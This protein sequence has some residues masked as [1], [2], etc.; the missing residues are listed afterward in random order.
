MKSARV[1]AFDSTLQTTNLWITEILQR[2]HWRDRHAAYH[3]LRSVLH[4]LRDR[5]TIEKVVALGA[6]L[7]M[8]IR[9]FY[10]EGWH[11]LASLTKNE[12]RRNSWNAFANPI[13]PFPKSAWKELFM[14]C[15]A[16]LPNM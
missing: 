3:A 11:P 13:R 8:L 2:L 1:A 14:P 16:F 10:Y 15:S 4:V 6:Q 12:P 7:P 9:G 5:L